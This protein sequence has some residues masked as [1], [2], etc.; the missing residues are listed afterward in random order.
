MLNI[1]N[2]E[3]CGGAYATILIN[4]KDKT[5]LKLFKSYNHPDL[6]GTGKEEE[7]ETETNEFRKKVYETEL[8]AYRNAQLSPLLKAHTPK[9]YGA[10][11]TGTI[12]NGE[13]EVTGHY[14]TNCCFQIEFIMGTHLKLGD[15]KSTTLLLSELEKKLEFTLE[16]LISEFNSNGVNYTKDSSV[17]YNTEQF[18]LIDFATIDC[19][20]FRPISKPRT[21]NPYDDIKFE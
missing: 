3:K 19:E 17:I 8:E 21:G 4:K 7:S 9:F 15:L 14:L 12:T 2:Y 6:D 5:V 11:Q 1:S 16:N 20:D 18:I 10:I 13:T